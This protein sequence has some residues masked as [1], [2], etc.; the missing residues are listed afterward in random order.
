VEFRNMSRNELRVIARIAL[1]SVG[2]YLLLQAA[3]SI[4]TI[5]PLALT[6]TSDELKN[7]TTIIAIAIYGVLT[8]SAIYFLVRLADR[9][10]VKIT[11]SEVVDDTQISWLAVAF[12][13][14][15]ITVGI[16]Y[17]YQTIFGLIPALSWYIQA[18]LGNET[19]SRYQHL[20]PEI[21]KLIVMLGLSI[22]LVCGAPGFVRWQVKKTIRQCNKTIE[23]QPTWG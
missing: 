6:A 1:I 5:L 17:L 7:N 9:F 20:W 15:C 12:R 22:Y 8:A 14:V 18:K 2:L 3:L 21:V 13:L 11:K 23:Q 19:M 10:A 16:I 4:L